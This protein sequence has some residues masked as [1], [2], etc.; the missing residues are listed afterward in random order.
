MIT[1]KRL[2]RRE[3]IV[4]RFKAVVE[5]NLHT[6]LLMEPVSQT[7]GTSSR[8][9]REA[10]QACLGMSPKQYAKQRRLAAVRSALLTEKRSITIIATRYGFFELGRFAGHYRARYGETPSNTLRKLISGTI[11][12]ETA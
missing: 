2:Q 6:V 3:Q 11:N 7:I 4:E 5:N 10:C 12:V 9:L 8:S 1:S